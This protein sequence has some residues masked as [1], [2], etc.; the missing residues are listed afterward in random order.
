LIQR[1]RKLVALAVLAGLLVWQG[2]GSAQTPTAGEEFHYQWRLSNLVGVL[3][4]LFFPREG[5][6][7][8][9]YTP[10]KNGTLRSELLI[11]SP[12]SAGEYWRYGADI[13]A[14]TL[15]PLRTWSSYAWRGR[16]KSRTREIEQKGVL[17]VVSAI[18]LIRRDPPHT[19]QLI[20][21]VTDGDVFPV[22]IIPRG[23]EQRKIGGRTMN[24]AHFAIRPAEVPGRLRWK[25]KVDVWLA[26][27]ASSTPVEIDISRS[28][29]DLRLELD[30][31][32]VSNGS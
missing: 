8:L 5:R 23:L 10:Q 16:L 28:L 11:T 31:V 27:D 18:Y 17:D 19:K 21:I 29:A 13:D 6:G 26:L 15:Q 7:D 25:G 22:E 14:Q 4:G 9:S 1:L 32:S 2:V 24:A 3:A 30:G 12:Q 20:D